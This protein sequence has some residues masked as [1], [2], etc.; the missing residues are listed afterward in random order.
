MIGKWF[1]RN[2]VTAVDE[3]GRTPLHYA[4]VEGDLASV[5]RLV[6]DGAD[7]NAQD[8]QGWSPLHC[9]AQGKSAEVTSALLASGANL[10]ARD[11]WGNT[12]LWRAVSASRGNGDAI[13][14][15]R[16]AGADPYAKNDS[17][18]SPVE[19]A[20]MVANYDLAQFFADLP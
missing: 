9:A 16:S 8:K 18:V 12:P 11:A 3:F 2:S 5:R 15:L 17:D 19:S 14:V 7:V 6:R 4:A 13:R 20:R 1:K 10:E